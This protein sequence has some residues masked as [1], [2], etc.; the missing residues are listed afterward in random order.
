MKGCTH[1]YFKLK[2]TEIPLINYIKR[3]KRGFRMINKYLSFGILSGVTL[4][5]FFLTAISSIRDNFFV[6]LLL[7][8]LA[9]GIFHSIFV[10]FKSIKNIKNKKNNFDFL[11]FIS[12]ILG[13]LGAYI[14]NIYLNQGAIIAASLVGIVGAL[15]VNKRAVAIY[16]GA[17]VGM[18][19]P[20]LLHDFS[21]ILIACIIAGIIFEFADEVFNGIGGKLGTIAFS[22]W[23]ILFILSDLNL[24]NPTMN[25][26]L[27]LE[28]FL[29]SLIGVL[30]TYFLH[31]YLKKDV[32][33]SS[34]IV[35][36]IGALILPQIFPQSDSNLSVLMMAATF[37]GMSSK[38]RLENFYEIFL[39]AFFVAVFFVYSYTHLGGGGGK[40]GTIAFG[41]VL[42]SNGIIRIIKYFKKNYQNFLNL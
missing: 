41:C 24:I 2:N 16:T 14:L 1:R 3:N 39:I 20:E 12:L 26:T 25:G 22:S 6:F 27:S 31:I 17:F 34:A 9:L 29:I 4:Y 21:H 38:E 37:A 18:V 5:L 23:I 8:F 32:V 28:I 19:S 42:G 13:G 35:S 10:E 11:N 15:L 40:L 30:S 36:L 7:L 33:G